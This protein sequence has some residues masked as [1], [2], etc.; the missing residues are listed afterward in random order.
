M[1]AV[2][3]C[4]GTFFDVLLEY[5][6]L[7]VL[8]MPSTARVGLLDDAHFRGLRLCYVYPPVDIVLDVMLSGCNYTR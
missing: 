8:A 2:P 3:C 6:D 4:S 1:L 5:S 7:A